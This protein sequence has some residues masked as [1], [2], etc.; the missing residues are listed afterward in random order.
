M[1][2]NATN[3]FEPARRSPRE[4]GFFNLRVLIGLCIVLSGVFLA[5]ASVGVF[6]ATGQNI[7]Q[8]LQKYKIITTSTDPLVPVGLDCSTIHEKGIDKQ[9]N[10]RAG[11]IMIA[12][13]LAPGGSTS[14]T[15]TST[16]GPIGRFFQKLFTPMA[17][18]AADV[19]LINHP[20]TSP[21]ITQSE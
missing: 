14:T 1:K 19:D 5:L 8:A 7:A 3:Q 20:E 6:S 10:M 16:L 4:G 12:C 15:A 17:Y 18:G 21:N 9:E 13:G 11:A 2:K